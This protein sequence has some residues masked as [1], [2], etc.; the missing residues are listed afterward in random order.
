MPATIPE[1]ARR[2]VSAAGAMDAVRSRHASRS[3]PVL[4][5]MSHLRVVVAVTASRLRPPRQEVGAAVAGPAGFGP[6]RAARSLLAVADGRDPVRR[7]PPRHEVV[8]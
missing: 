2:P 7:H 8:A 3:T 6:L 5:I 1:N 4:V